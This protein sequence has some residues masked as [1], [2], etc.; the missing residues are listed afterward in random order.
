MKKRS[1]GVFDGRCFNP[2]DEHRTGTEEDASGRS[3]EDDV[4]PARSSSARSSSAFLKNAINCFAKTHTKKKRS[5]LSPDFPGNRAGV[6]RPA[7]GAVALE[8]CH[9]T[10]WSCHVTQRAGVEFAAEL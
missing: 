4:L 7:Y 5:L 9:H 1:V 10:D 2:V 6:W 3:L 8:S